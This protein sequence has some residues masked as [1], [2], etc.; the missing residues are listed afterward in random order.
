MNKF[1]E[2]WKKK[3]PLPT[4][5]DIQNS[6]SLRWFKKYL[7]KPYLWSFQKNNVANSAFIGLFVACLPMPFQMLVACIF[8]I[9]FR[10]NIPIAVALTWV[11]NPVTMAPFVY[12]SYKIGEFILNRQSAALESI[13]L[14]YLLDNWHLFWQNL[15]LGSIMLGIILGMLGWAFVH[16]FWRSI[17]KPFRIHHKPKD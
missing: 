14:S 13:N 8:S 4:L 10:A 7:G 12:A 15:L 1:I 5:E 9:I 11:S 3:H 2:N 6:K 17:Y 16:I